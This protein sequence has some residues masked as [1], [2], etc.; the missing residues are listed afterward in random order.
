[1]ISAIVLA[2]DFM[3]YLYCS[4]DDEPD[5][6]DPGEVWKYIPDYLPV[7][8]LCEVTEPEI[9]GILYGPDGEELLV[10][11]DKDQFPFGFCK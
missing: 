10:M 1:M 11:Y 2:L 8:P 5:W 7:A 6:G 4:E 9:T 3:G